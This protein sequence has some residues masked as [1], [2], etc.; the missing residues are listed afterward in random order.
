MTKFKIKKEKRKYFCDRCR[1]ISEIKRCSWCDTDVYSDTLSKHR[2]YVEEV[3]PPDLKLRYSIWAK[4]DRDM[5][6]L[7]KK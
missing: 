1:N 7:L 3:N 4:R 6:K 5:Q 2:K